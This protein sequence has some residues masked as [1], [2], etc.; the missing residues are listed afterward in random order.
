MMQFYFFNFGVTMSTSPDFFWGAD[1]IMMLPYFNK[2]LEAEPS[3]AFFGRIVGLCFF[4]LACGPTFFGVS[5][6]GFTKQTL[7]FHFGSLYW[8]YTRMVEAAA[9]DTHIANPWV[10]QIQLLFGVAFGAW[11]LSTIGGASDKEKV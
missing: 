11:G 2:S 8:I 9:A 6:A 4:I 3:G 1:S 5:D 10:W 7:M